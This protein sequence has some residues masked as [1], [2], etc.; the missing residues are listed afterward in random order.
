MPVIKNVHLISAQSWT[1]LKTNTATFELRD[2]FFD[3]K[4]FLLISMI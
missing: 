3:M 2:E 4:L 1:Y